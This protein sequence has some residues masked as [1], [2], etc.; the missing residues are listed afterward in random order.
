VAL[1]SAGPIFY[2]LDALSDIQP[3]VSKHNN[4]DGAVIMARPL[5]EFTGF[6]WWTQTERQVDTNPQ[7]KPTNLACESTGMQL[8]STSCRHRLL[9]LS[10]RTDT[11]FTIPRRVEELALVMFLTYC[12]YFMHQLSVALHTWKCTPKN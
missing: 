8:P 12:Q 11:H 4:T 7:T 10:L 1:A 9:L 2:R 3:T 5:R 6:I